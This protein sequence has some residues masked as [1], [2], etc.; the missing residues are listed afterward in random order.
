METTQTSTPSTDEMRINKMSISTQWNI[1]PLYKKKDMY[2][3]MDE[4][5]KH[6]AKLKRPD[7]ESHIFNEICRTGKDKVV[8]KY[9]SKT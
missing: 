8:M 7:T 2:Y 4:C 6:Y 3:N 9:I 1:I 5:W